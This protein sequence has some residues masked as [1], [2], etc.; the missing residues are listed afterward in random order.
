MYC[1]VRRCVAMCKDVWL[2][3]YLLLFAAM[4]DDVFL[5][6]TKCFYV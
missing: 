6:V 2:C 5:C 4:F 3:D 1:Y